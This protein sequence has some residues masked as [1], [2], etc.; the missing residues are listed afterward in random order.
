M[1]KDEIKQSFKK[2]LYFR[3]GSLVFEKSGHVLTRSDRHY[4][5]ILNC[6][7]KCKRIEEWQI[8]TE[9]LNRKFARISLK[10]AIPPDEAKRISKKLLSVFLHKAV[11]EGMKDNPQDEVIETTLIASAQDIVKEGKMK[12]GDMTTMNEMFLKK[13]KN[14]SPYLLF[15]GLVEALSD[16]SREKKNQGQFLALITKK[17][18][19]SDKG[20]ITKLEMENLGW[21]ILNYIDKNIPNYLYNLKKSGVEIVNKDQEIISKDIFEASEY[22]KNQP[23]EILLS[24]FHSSTLMDIVKLFKESLGLLSF[25]DDEQARSVQI[26]AVYNAMTNLPAFQLMLPVTGIL[27]A[28][29]TTK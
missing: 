20:K 3:D 5:C 14:S 23:T 10:F 25:T 18:Y 17:I 26:W 6:N 29:K 12:K 28:K 22:F 21:Y 2:V 7:Q 9:S 19:L 11:D 4:R 24:S 8:K 1:E 16:F 27:K 13:Q 15:G